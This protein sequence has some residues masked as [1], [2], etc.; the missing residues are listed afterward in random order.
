MK[1]QSEVR[2]RTFQLRHALLLLALYGLSAIDVREAVL[3]P[4][5]RF[6]S[7]EAPIDAYLNK[8]G[9]GHGLVGQT[10]EGPC[11]AVPKPKFLPTGVHTCFSSIF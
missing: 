1:N 5:L 7:Y 11:S 8:G 3:L 2:Y 4:Y 10:L 6:R 9:G